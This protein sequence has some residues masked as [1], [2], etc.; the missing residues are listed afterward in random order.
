MVGVF[1]EWVR[2]LT[3]RPNVKFV[4]RLQEVLRS[5]EHVSLE[6]TIVLSVG[7]VLFKDLLH[8]GGTGF[9]SDKA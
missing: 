5:D 7:W 8:M 6:S 2:V 4:S 1:V 9:A 3:R